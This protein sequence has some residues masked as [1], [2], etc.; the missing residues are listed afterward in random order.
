MGRETDRLQ[1]ALDLLVLKTLARLGD[2]HGYAI[3]RH[4]QSVSRD[5]L[6]VEEGSLYP[7]LHRMTDEGLI[8]AEWGVS[9]AKRRARFYRLTETGR[10]RLAEEEAH[11]SRVT[12]AVALV[13]NED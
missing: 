8:E 12:A 10:R 13:L 5:A 9:D 2:A 3:T 11:W 1:G 7:A 6:K 4:I